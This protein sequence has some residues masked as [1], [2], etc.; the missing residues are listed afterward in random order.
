MKR[1]SIGWL[2]AALLVA[3]AWALAARRPAPASATVEVDR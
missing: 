2:A 3:L 1:T